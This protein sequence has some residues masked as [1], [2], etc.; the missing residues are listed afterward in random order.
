MD[1][2]Q[3]N[4]DLQ[5]SSTNIVQLTDDVKIL[6][7]STPPSSMADLAQIKYYV[8]PGIFITVSELAVALV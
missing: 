7:P 2:S 8:P 3:E 4:A 6:A 1:F 5:S